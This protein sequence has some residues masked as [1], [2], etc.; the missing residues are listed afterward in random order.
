MHQRPRRAPA[1]LADRREFRR[2]RQG[3]GVLDGV[4]HRGDHRL[5][6]EIEHAAHKGEVAERYPHHGGRTRGADRRDAGDRALVAEQAVLIVARHRRKTLARQHLGQD[7]HPEGGP[8][9]MHGL[10]GAQPAGEGEGRGHAGGT[11]RRAEGP[12]L[13]RRAG[14]LSKH[15]GHR[16]RQPVGAGGSVGP[17]ALS[18]RTPYEAATAE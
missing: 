11:G 10:A 8:A 13:G 12:L 1:A 15:L 16:I 17:L 18:T 7:R 6:A 14:S 5:G 9:D 2:R 3:A 4:D